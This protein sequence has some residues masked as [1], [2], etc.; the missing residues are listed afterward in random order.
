MKQVFSVLLL[1]LVIGACRKASPGPTEPVQPKQVLI[2]TRPRACLRMPPPLPPRPVEIWLAEGCPGD[3]VDGCP[4]P[5]S[6]VVD[7]LEGW[8]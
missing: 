2:P 3:A 4:E 6:E 7:A 1:V 8:A 5:G